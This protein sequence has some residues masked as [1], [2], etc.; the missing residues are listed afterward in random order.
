VSADTATVMNRLLNEVVN[1]KGGTGKEARLNS[2]MPVIGKTGTTQDW[3]DLTFVGMTPYYIGG[4]WTGYDT[5]KQLPYKSIYDPDTIWKNVMQDVHKGLPVKDFEQSDQVLE[6]EYCTYSGLLK[7]SHCT[8]TAKGYYKASAKPKVCD[9]YHTVK[10]PSETSSSDISGINGESGSSSTSSTPSSPSESTGTP[11][12]S[13][14]QG[15]MNA[16]VIE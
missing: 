3:N 2:K 15:P 9:V 5:P 10:E 12:S 1:G 16:P 11:N 14:V 8:S 4:V 6:L 13:E 7:S